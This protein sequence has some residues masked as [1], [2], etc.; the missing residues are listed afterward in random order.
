MPSSGSEWR[1]I[2]RR[3]RMLCYRV[4]IEIRSGKPHLSSIFPGSLPQNIQRAKEKCHLVLSNDPVWQSDPSAR[5]DSSGLDRSEFG[6]Y[7]ILYNVIY[8][9]CRSNQIRNFDIDPFLAWS[10][11]YFGCMA[12]CFTL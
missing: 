3:V 10:A 9:I 11:V 7:F 4:G 2:R 8:K 5:K 1:E 6:K 12:G